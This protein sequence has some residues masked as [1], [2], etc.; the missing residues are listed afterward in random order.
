MGVERL[1]EVPYPSYF[2]C[3]PDGALYNSVYIPH[4]VSDEEALQ[5][6]VMLASQATVQTRICSNSKDQVENLGVALQKLDYTV[7]WGGNTFF[8][9][10]LATLKETRE[11]Y[12]RFNWEGFDEDFTVAR[13]G[14]FVNDREILKSLMIGSFGR[15]RKAGGFEPDDKKIKQINK[16]F[17]EAVMNNKNSIYLVRGKSNPEEVLGGFVLIYHA[18]LGEVQVHCV[19]GIGDHPKIIEYPEK[20]KV[21]MPAVFQATADEFQK[22][23]KFGIANQSEINYSDP[24]SLTFSASGIASYYE[25]LGFQASNRSGVVVYK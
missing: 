3:L 18:G 21:I 5:V 4:D 13:M 14:S 6:G 12:P 8:E 1:G 11:R 22:S 9:S 10:P 16:I 23:R 7:A 24:A 25:S 17:D 2:Y 15:T 19:S 20:L